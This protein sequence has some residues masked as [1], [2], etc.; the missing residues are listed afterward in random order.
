MALTW[1]LLHGAPFTP[2]VW[3]GVAERL[4]P[5]GVV[6]RPDLT[7]TGDAATLQRTIAERVLALVGDLPGE[8]H[9]VGHSSGG[10]IALAMALCATPGRVRSLTLIC[11]R[12]TP[13]GQLAEAADAL[14]RG[15]PV[16]IDGAVSRWFRPRELDPEGPIVEYARRCVREAD[17]A[18]WADAL[19][20]IAVY[21]RSDAV[22][23]LEIPV[24]LIA[25]AFD[26]LATP[27]EMN[28]LR[29]RIHGSRLHVLGG[30]S[31]M[32]P[33][34]DPERLGALILGVSS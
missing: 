34:A 9:L 14:R 24:T 1:L 28:G 21:D 2:A 7:S 5:A 32:S 6:L 8:L 4:E 11:S 16:D 12:S 31:H 15:E 20:A 18:A 27:E 23:S 17:R 22:A 33:F 3:A 10:Q 25:G 30:A 13:L 29:E 26:Q 19:D